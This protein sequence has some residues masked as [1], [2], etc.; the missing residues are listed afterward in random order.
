MNLNK[1][2]IYCKVVE[3]GSVTAAAEHFHVTQPVISSH[4]RNLE[5]FFGAKLL[6]VEKRR[7]LLTE[8]G[9]VV[10][11]YALSI[12]HATASTRSFASALAAGDAGRVVIG[13]SYGPGGYL[14]PLQLSRF[15]AAH[16]RVQI[17]LA[18]VGSSKV[19]EGLADGLYDIGIVTSDDVP[20]E[21]DTELLSNEPLALIAAPGH[22]LAR[23]RVIDTAMLQQAE[24]VFP[25][26]PR[27]QVWVKKRLARLGIKEPLVSMKLGSWEAT[28]HAAMAGAGLIL[29]YRFCVE[30]ELRSKHLK[31][32]PVQI[33]PLT[34]PVILIRSPR[35]RYTTMQEQLVAFLHSAMN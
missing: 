2:E 23:R 35:R 14:L 7:M 24:F 29:A 25:Y 22:P 20:S 10:Y 21:F 28:K 30:V 31:A 34:E 8:A 19:I 26:S 18:V 6:Y 15:R 1:L 11:D 17:E 3:E 33:D 12:R 4:L 13:A 16:P 9:R 5:T 32:L 27:T